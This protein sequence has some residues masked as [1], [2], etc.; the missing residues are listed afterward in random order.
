MTSMKHVI[1]VQH[2]P[3]EPPGTISEVSWPKNS[4]TEY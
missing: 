3:Y 4:R 2:V 1:V